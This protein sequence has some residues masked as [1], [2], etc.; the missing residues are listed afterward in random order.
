MIEYQTE[1]YI[2]RLVAAL[3]EN[4]YGGYCLAFVLIGHRVHFVIVAGTLQLRW[5]LWGGLQV[6]M[7]Q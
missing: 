5:E 7:S 4:P 3:E 6:G 2:S 1:P